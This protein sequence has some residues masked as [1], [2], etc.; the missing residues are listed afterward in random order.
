MPQDVASS[1]VCPFCAEEIKVAAVLCRY[2]GSTQPEAAASSPTVEFQPEKFGF[3]AL[4]DEGRTVPAKATDTA[5]QSALADARARHDAGEPPQDRVPLVFRGTTVNCRLYDSADGRRVVAGDF[6]N[7][8]PVAVDLVVDLTLKSAS[9]VVLHTQRIDAGIS[10][11]WSTVSWHAAW[12]LGTDWVPLCETFWAQPVAVTFWPV[13]DA[14]ERLAA[15]EA[16]QPKATVPLASWRG[17]KFKTQQAAIH[18]LCQS[19][20]NRGTHA[21][22]DMN[23][24]A[25]QAGPVQGLWRN[26]LAFQQGSAYGSGEQGRRIAADWES[27]RAHRLFNHAWAAVACAACGSAD[28]LVS[29]P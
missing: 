19:C 24:L 5:V 17:R 3:P 15:W 26:A 11:P 23:F 8:T 13:A 27:D 7:Q 22:S 21:G 29:S 18:Y 12:R 16:A 14:V 6:L 20:G 4:V 2:C 1:K 10:L 28:Q 25:A 9:E